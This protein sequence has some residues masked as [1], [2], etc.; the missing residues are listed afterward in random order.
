MPNHK[1]HIIIG[2]V[3]TAIVFLIIIKTQVVSTQLVGVDWVMLAMIVYLY[4]QL[5]DI[6]QDLSVINRIWNTTAALGGI[7]ALYTGKYKLLGI[8]AIASILI[9]E[10]V[11]HRGVC[12]ELWFGILMAAPLWFLNPLFAIV[13]ATCYVSHLV[14]D[15]ELIKWK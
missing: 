2:M 7:Y 9:L 6:D 10:W 12:H 8:F 4:S 3:V 1:I 13:G 5:P 15:G 11:K 14:A